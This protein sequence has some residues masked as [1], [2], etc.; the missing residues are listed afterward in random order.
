MA[1]ET[2]MAEAADPL[3]QA[4]LD[5][6]ASQ[7]Q[8]DVS[9]DTVSEETEEPQ[10]ESVDEDGLPVDQGPRSELGR[11]VAAIH[12]RQDEFDSKIDRMLAIIEAQNKPEPET[13]SDEDDDMPLTRKEIREMMR[14]EREQE[15]KSAQE[16]Q[17]KYKEGYVGTL[18]RLAR[19]V[20]E[21]EY[22]L[23]L[24][25]M[26]TMTYDPTNDPE[27]DAALNFY[28]AQVAAAKK[29][30]SKR[31]NPI[32]GKAPKSELGTVINQK[33]V[34]KESALPKLDPAAQSYLSFVTREDGEDKAVA[35]RKSMAK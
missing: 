1:D 35:L 23:I 30:V 34:D 29:S 20:D 28:K 22:G 12:R 4:A 17:E 9:D 2:N 18:A 24:E 16:T 19:D 33:T 6:V 21:A 8:E 10:E 5:A 13:I 27:K 7:E 14:R 32:K 25:E 15:T 3:D 26:K 31:E 11:K